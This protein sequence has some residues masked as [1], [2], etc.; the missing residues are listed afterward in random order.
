M[1]VRSSPRAFLEGDHASRRAPSRRSSKEPG[2]ARGA[3]ASRCPQRERRPGP[4][5]RTDSVRA[6]ALSGTETVRPPTSTR[7][8]NRPVPGVGTVN[9]RPTAPVACATSRPPWNTVTWTPVSGRGRAFTT[10]GAP[11]NAVPGARLDVNLWRYR[12]RGLRRAQLTPARPPVAALPGKQREV[13]T[14]ERVGRDALHGL[15]RRPGAALEDNSRAALAGYQ[16][17]VEDRAL[18]EHDQRRGDCE[19]ERLRAHDRLGGRRAAERVGHDEADDVAARLREAVRDRRSRR[20]GSV[21]EV[22]AV[23][24]DRGAR[25]DHGRLRGEPDGQR[26]GTGERR[27]GDARCGR[28]RRSRRGQTRTARIRSR[29]TG[30]L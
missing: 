8:S 10:I 28:A 5:S 26:R 2:R 30:R 14:S 24:G 21:A 4:S 25:V 9:C 11:R 15:P 20:G 16:R 12:Q 18:P 1:P 29:R 23:R 17:A 6:P 7:A 3:P 22:P 27:G 13:E 19:A